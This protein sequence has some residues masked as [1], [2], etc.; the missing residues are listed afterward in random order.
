METYCRQVTKLGRLVEEKFPNTVMHY[1]ADHNLQLTTQ[2]EYSGDIAIRLGGIANGEKNEEDDIVKTL[3]NAWNLVSHINQSP[4]A[5]AKLAN[6]Q[7]IV[8]P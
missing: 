5:N 8:S 3:K 2:K 7:K 6:A 1:C 4:L